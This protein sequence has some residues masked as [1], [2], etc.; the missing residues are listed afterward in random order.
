MIEPLLARLDDPTEDQWVR[1]NV[2]K[3][4]ITILSRNAPEPEPE[5]APCELQSVPGPWD[6]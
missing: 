5:D 2:Y 4:L 6:E 1:R 3:A